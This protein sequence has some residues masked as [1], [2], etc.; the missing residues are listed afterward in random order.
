MRKFWVVLFLCP[1]FVWSNDLITALSDGDLM[2]DLRLRWENV[3]QGN[4]DQDSTAITL[5]SR[6]GWR[7]AE[8]RGWRLTVEFENLTAADDNSYNDTINGEPR[9]VIADPENTEVNRLYLEYKQ[10]DHQWLLGRQRLRMGTTRFIGNAPWR[11]GEHT[12]DGIVY[13]GSFGGTKVTAGWLANQ[14]RLFGEQHPNPLSANW[15]MNTIVADAAIPL[16]NAGNLYAFTHFIDVDELPDLGHRNLG[17]RWNGKAALSDETKLI[18]ELTYAQQDDYADGSDAFDN[19]YQKV[20]IGP[21]WSIFSITANYEVL[22]GN[23]QQG[24]ITPLASRH[25]PNGWADRF[26]NTPVVGLE[27]TFIQITARPK[28]WLIVAQY[29][30]FEGESADVDFGSELDL[31][32]SYTVNKQWNVNAKMADFQGEA[33]DDATKLW[34]WTGYAF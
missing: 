18:Y 31:R 28:G 5:R 16:G 23:G 15:R 2:L 24:F 30:E 19:G 9:P 7:T 11:Q 34:L 10:G 17:L 13:K 12:F 25:G 21:E 22:E 33:I 3:D 32:F 4:I 20:V 29:H 27:D 26:L 1:S 14:N 8:Y 6:L